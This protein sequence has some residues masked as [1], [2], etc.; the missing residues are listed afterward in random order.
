MAPEDDLH[1]GE[2]RH[3]LFGT[4]HHPTHR[5]LFTVEGKTV[6]VLSAGLLKE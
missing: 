6:V 4:G 5:I 2:V 1:D 3:L